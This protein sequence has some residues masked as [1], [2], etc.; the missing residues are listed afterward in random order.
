MTWTCG[1]LVAPQ[2]SAMKI[3]NCLCY[4]VCGVVLVRSSQNKLI[5]FSD[6]VFLFV[7]EW[8]QNYTNFSKLPPFLANKFSTKLSPQF[9]HT[10]NLIS[11]LGTVPRSKKTHLRFRKRYFEVSNKA[12]SVHVKLN[13]VGY[14]SLQLSI[15]EESITPHIFKIRIIALFFK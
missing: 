13:L 5:W 7:V 2:R 8:R 12:S 6:V 3:V 11:S 4:L 10:W 1:S 14:F 9:W 15:T